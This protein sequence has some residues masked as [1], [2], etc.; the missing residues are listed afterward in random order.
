[1]CI[2]LNGSDMDRN[3]LHGA[4][5]LSALR[6]T[7]FTEREWM[8]SQRSWEGLYKSVTHEIT[9]L[10]VRRPI[11]SETRVEPESSY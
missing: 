3:R 9:Y 2:G 1:M 11:T 10:L 7:R 8:I 4:G 5:V 6:K